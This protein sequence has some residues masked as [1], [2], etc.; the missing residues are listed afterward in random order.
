MTPIEKNIIVVDEKGNQYEA[1]YAKRAKGLVK[2]GR[3]RFIDVNTIC[4][5]CPPNNNTEDN[6]MPENKSEN[7]QNSSAKLSVDY[8]LKKIEEISLEK[9]ILLDAISEIGKLKSIGPGDVGTQEQAKAIG[10]I[11]KARETTNQRLIA[12]YEKMYDDLKLEKDK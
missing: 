5:A 4:L 12:L 9:S 1:T 10:E 2:N 11:I 6:Y 7:I 8:L 3:A